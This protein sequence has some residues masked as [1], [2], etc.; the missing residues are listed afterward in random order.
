[1][2]KK[3]LQTLEFSKIIQAVA[4]LAASDLGKEQVLTL[5]PS[6]D[7]EEVEL[8]QDETEDGTNYKIKR[9]YAYSKVTK[10]SSTFK[11]VGYR[12]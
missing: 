9:Q 4:N 6:I 11:T 5:A 8:W 2:N 7:K 10:R 12:C 1:M 3:I